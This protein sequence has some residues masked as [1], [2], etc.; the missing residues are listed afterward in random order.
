M[1]AQQDSYDGEVGPV[2]NQEDYEQKAL[3]Y[4]EEHPDREVTGQWRTTF[5]SSMCVINWVEF[6]PKFNILDQMRKNNLNQCLF[7]CNDNKETVYITNSS[8]DDN[9]P[10]PVPNQH[11]DKTCLAHATATVI[12]FLQDRFNTKRES[13]KSLRD[14]FIPK[15]HGNGE[16]MTWQEQRTALYDICREKGFR[17]E[18]VNVNEACRAVRD[19]RPVVAI[20]DLAKSQWNKFNDF[21]TPSSTC[22]GKDLNNKILKQ[23]DLG[24]EEGNLSRHAILFV[25]YC[26][27]RENSTQMK[28]YLR[29]LNSWGAEFGSA[30]GFKIKD[31]YVL[32]NMEFFSIH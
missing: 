2:W 21:F 6:P 24:P 9:Y 3:K 8:L 23:Q 1:E 20:F 7:N 13:F 14:Q 32:K 4:E 10:F 25:G 26:K 28:E 19:L 17:C 11:Q 22:R 18:K 31:E 15:L 30:G 29:F 27:P 16:E 5:P 12:Y